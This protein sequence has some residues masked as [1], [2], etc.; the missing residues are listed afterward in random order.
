M[1][2]SVFCW[3]NTKPEVLIQFFFPS[4]LNV[5]QASCSPVA[6]EAL[7]LSSVLEAGA[8]MKNDHRSSRFEL[9]PLTAQS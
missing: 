9:A 1:L 2:F 4:H 8:Q 5:Q 7:R 6:E 3:L